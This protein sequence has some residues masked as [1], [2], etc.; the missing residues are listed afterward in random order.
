MDSQG[1]NSCVFCRIVSGKAG[2]SLLHADDHVVAFPDIAPKAPTHV[3]VVPRRHVAS[4]LDVPSH[5]G[6]VARL[7]QVAC[8]IARKGGLDKGGFRLVL[9]TGA[10]GGQSVF[11]LHLHLLGGRAMAWPPG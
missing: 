8:A 1:G 4:V 11:H 2:A 10:D 5:D 9:N 7:A 6:I 3:L